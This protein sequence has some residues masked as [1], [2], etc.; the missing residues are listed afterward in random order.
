MKD[1]WAP[2]TRL[3]SV[4]V[5]AVQWHGRARGFGMHVASNGHHQNLALPDVDSTNF[6]EGAN[7]AKYERR[8]T[9]ATG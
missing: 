7:S 6:V 5:C 4:G 1:S 9:H 8:K 2:A 3:S